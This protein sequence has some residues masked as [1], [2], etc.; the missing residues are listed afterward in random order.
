MDN[1]I[2]KGIADNP[3]LFQAVKEAV[4]AEFR[5]ITITDD[6]DDNVI[7]QKTRAQLVG[8]KAVEEAF[9]KIGQYKTVPDP[10][11]RVNQAR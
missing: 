9:R 10:I 6:M 4:L 7:G 8:S 1:Q 11:P 3:S 2:L 5:S